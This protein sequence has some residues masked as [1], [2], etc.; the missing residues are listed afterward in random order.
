MSVSLNNLRRTGLGG[1]V[2]HSRRGWLDEMGR[3]ALLA[4]AAVCLLVG[5]I[6]GW[7]ATTPPDRGIVAKG[8]V[9]FSGAVEKVLHPTG[10]IVAEIL[11]QDGTRVEAGDLLV[12][13]DDRHARARLDGIV[14]QLDVLALRHGRFVAE[15]DGAAGLVLA[16]SITPRVTLPEVVRMMVVETELLVERR[17]SMALG[18]RRLEDRIV[19]L[20]EEVGSLEGLLAAKA[21]VLGP[22]TIDRGRSGPPFKN[23]RAAF[24]LSVILDLA[25]TR[26]EV[27]IERLV[28]A[29]AEVRAG[30]SLLRGQI[31]Q[32]ESDGRSV[33][34]DELEEVEARIAALEEQRLAEEEQL[35]RIDIRAPQ[36]GVVHRLSVFTAGGV[37]NAGEPVMLIVSSGD[38]LALDVAIAPGEVGRVGPGQQAN[39]R[40]NFSDG[41]LSPEITARVESITTDSEQSGPKS[42]SGSVVRLVLDPSGLNGLGAHALV[43]GM[44]GAVYIEAEERS[45]IFRFLEAISDRIVRVFA[46][47]VSWFDNRS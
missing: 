16:D 3:R 5:G 40:L 19:R 46:G 1:G 36:G 7:A 23:G 18:K 44:K 12:L 43:P 9:V 14:R 45:A 11:V 8:T 4:C 37:I 47:N 6:G 26:A 34:L 29:I 17:G 39:V 31:V 32:L 24:S 27:E 42:S 33:L 30:I 10:G 13:L 35:A 20:E 38:T 41:R 21:G 2:A 25:G 15:R 22:A 28:S